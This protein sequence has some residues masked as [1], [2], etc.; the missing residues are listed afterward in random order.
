MKPSTPLHNLLVSLFLRRSNLSRKSTSLAS[1]PTTSSATP[2]VAAATTT[3]TSNSSTPASSTK[4]SLSASVAADSSSSDEKQKFFRL[5]AF[6]KRAKAQQQ[7]QQQQK[8]KAPPARVPP[9]PT[10]ESSDEEEKEEDEVEEEEEEETTS[11]DSEE[12]YYSSEEQPPAANKSSSDKMSKKAPFICDTKDDKPW[13]FAAAAAKLSVDSSPFFSNITNTFGATLPKLDVPI[14]EKS[15]FGLCL[16]PKSKNDHKHM[17][18][19]KKSTNREPQSRPKPPGSGQLRGLFDGLSHFFA[20][21]GK[22]T[23]R[24]KPGAPPPNYAPDRRKR[25]LQIQQQENTSTKRITTPTATLTPKLAAPKMPST[26]T[27]TTV[28]P[29]TAVTTEGPT[30]GKKEVAKVTRIPRPGIFT[31]SEEGAN[32]LFEL[33][34][35]KPSKMTP[36]GLVKTAVNSKRHEQ[37]RRKLRGIDGASLVK[38]AS[39]E[40]ISKK[41]KEQQQQHPEP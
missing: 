26:T 2:A 40:D 13:G 31:P 39:Q 33:T 3:A 27:R 24:A 28:A 34:G 16:D 29:T 8:A 14:G 38:C 21:S 36:S 35:E 4:K 18:E 6:N 10:E 41:K 11:D 30:R 7:Q 1:T 20:A 19:S 15:T 25:Q 5:S 17:Q 22:S 23:S 32:C 37:E 9:L 12:E